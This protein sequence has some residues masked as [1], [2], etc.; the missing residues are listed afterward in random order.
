MLLHYIGCFTVINQKYGF[1][2]T[3]RK[4]DKHTE[5]QSWFTNT[6]VYSQQHILSSRRGEREYENWV[7]RFS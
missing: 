7:E 2:V 6:K 1:N 5:I 4:S 3:V